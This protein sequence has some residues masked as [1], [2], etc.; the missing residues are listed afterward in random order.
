LNVSEAV[1]GALEEALLVKHI[2]R[3]AGEFSLP[4]NYTPFQDVRIG[5]IERIQLWANP[6]MFPRFEWF[7]KGEGGSL[8]ERGRIYKAPRKQEEALAFLLDQ[9]KSLGPGHEIYYYEAADKILK[10]LGYHVVKVIVPALTH[11]YLNETL[12]PLGTKRLREVPEK[13]GYK[14]TVFPNPLP[15]PFP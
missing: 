3:S 14:K 9:L 15:H 11:L 12:A 13:L 1:L 7:L 4:D 2:E 8:K 10:R 5:H 6:A